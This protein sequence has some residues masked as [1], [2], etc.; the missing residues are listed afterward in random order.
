MIPA[1]NKAPLPPCWR[2]SLART[3]WP[4]TNH[5]LLHPSR[6]LK[7]AVFI[8][9][10]D[11]LHA[12]LGPLQPL[13][14]V[15]FAQGWLN[16]RFTQK[17]SP[18]EDPTPWRLQGHK[19]LQISVCCFVLAFPP[20]L[21]LFDALVWQKPSPLCLY[22]HKPVCVLNNPQIFSQCDDD[23]QV[24]VKY[25]RFSLLFQ[26]IRLFH[27]FQQQRDYFNFPDCLKINM[28]INNVIMW[29]IVLK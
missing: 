28:K 5:P 6:P 3:W 19:H 21:S 13:L 26:G 4:F 15:S 2:R 18:L 29:K 24:L 14:L 12:S 20:L 7:I 1:Q 25:P 27:A 23:T 8:S 22:L 11:S 10:L 17:C 16:R 9:E